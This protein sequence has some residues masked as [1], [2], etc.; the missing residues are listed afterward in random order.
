MEEK[1]LVSHQIS[2]QEWQ[3]IELIRRLGYGELV[4]SVKEGKPIRA[5]EVRK[6]IQIK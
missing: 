4:I 2:N 5:E 3:V 6:S 1:N